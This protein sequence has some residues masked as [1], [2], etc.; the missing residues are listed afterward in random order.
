MP[1]WENLRK[2]AGHPV[3]KLIQQIGEYFWN[4]LPHS[5]ILF[6]LPNDCSIPNHLAPLFIL[7]IEAIFSPHLGFRVVVRKTQVFRSLTI[8][9]LSNHGTRTTLFLLR[10]SCPK[11]SSKTFTRK[12]AISLPI[13]SNHLTV[14][15]PV[16]QISFPYF[17]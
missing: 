5:I 14:H 3:L 12:I 7:N 10:N 4:R 17:P 11:M 15:G 16:R 2:I 9:N 13:V 8:T 1:W 6:N